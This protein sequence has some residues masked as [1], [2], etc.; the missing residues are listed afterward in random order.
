MKYHVLLQLTLSI[1]LVSTTTHG[2]PLF[3]EDSRIGKIVKGWIRR[4]SLSLDKVKR[5]SIKRSY[6][7]LAP[8]D[9]VP[10]LPYY[11]CEVPGQPYLSALFENPIS[12]NVVGAPGRPG[13]QANEFCA[14]HGKKLL[15]LSPSNFVNAT[16]DLANI[17]QNF[18]KAYINSY[19]GDQTDLSNKTCLVLNLI[20][21]G[22]GAAVTVNDCSECLP[23]ICG[24]IDITPVEIPDYSCSRGDSPANVVSEHETTFKLFTPGSLGSSA[25]ETCKINGLVLADVTNDKF[26]N[27]SKEIFYSVGR[28]GKAFIKSING[29]QYDGKC[30]SLALHNHVAGGTVLVE[31]CDKCLPV[32]CST[33]SQVVTVKTV[34]ITVTLGSNETAQVTAT[35][36]P[37]ILISP[38]STEPTASG[39]NTVWVTIFV[40]PTSSTLEQSTTEIP[41]IESETQTTEPESSA[42]GSDLI[43]TSEPETSSAVTEVVTTDSATV[44][45][46]IETLIFTL[47]DAQSVYVTTIIETIYETITIED[48]TTSIINTSVV[49]QVIETGTEVKTTN[50]STEEIVTS[51]PESSEQAS[52]SATGEEL[53]TE[54]EPTEELTLINTSKISASIPLEFGTETSTLEIP[55]DEV[56]LEPLPTETITGTVSPETT[57][58]ESQSIYTTIVTITITAESTDSI[59]LTLSTEIVTV[60]VTA[61]ANESELPTLEASTNEELSS[62]TSE[63]PSPE[64]IT[65][66]STS[67]LASSESTEESFLTESETFTVEN[68]L[69]TSIVTVTVTLQA[70]TSESTTELTSSDSTI[71][72]ITANETL[73]TEIVTVTV[74]PESISS[75]STESG[76]ESTTDGS[77]STTLSTEIVTITV[78]PESSSSETIESGSESPIL[79]TEIVTVT[80]TVPPSTE[81]ITESKSLEPVSSSETATESTI[82]EISTTFDTSVETVVLTLTLDNNSEATVTLDT[83][84]TAPETTESTSETASPSEYFP[85]D[86]EFETVFETQIVD[87]TSEESS[88]S[89][90]T[91][92][93]TTTTIIETLTVTVSPPSSSTSESTFTLN[94]TLSTSIETTTITDT[95]VTNSV[96]TTTEISPTTQEPTTVSTTTLES[97]TNSTS[98]QESTTT[99]TT[100]QETTT[101]TVASPTPS[102]NFYTCNNNTQAELQQCSENSFFNVYTPGRRASEAGALCKSYGEKLAWPNTGKFSAAVRTAKKCAG[103]GSRVW[104]QG[105]DNPTTQCTALVISPT[106]SFL[107]FVPND[108]AD[109]LPVLCTVLNN[110]AT[111]IRT[112]TNT[113]SITP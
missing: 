85:T 54:A 98:T 71:S 100:T 48:A 8:R 32:L 38:D 80:I 77:S 49:S 88:S 101:T 3:K 34:Y 59:E 14:G 56:T 78:T 113:V 75:E 51:E 45:P 57:T 76:T 4:E 89:S 92:E 112:T 13:S 50:T 65:E 20:S 102:P 110:T 83:P 21:K 107:G 109:C 25:E 93:I 30:L 108:C 62:E 41:S 70:T 35:P 1:L 55:T 7:E 33:P 99:T 2:R 16:I 31:E 46:V 86:G 91:T 15:D 53:S 60:T 73:S 64:P 81:S 61:E 68:I 26:Y 52:E 22:P 12:G 66:E 87:V 58:T 111:T 72:D 43:T 5:S 95:S 17:G 96:I 37:Q 29:N 47:T 6:V 18:D 63:T 84:T 27:A 67:E 19:L 24:P 69:S 23:V 10:P 9:L 106:G 105:F 28:W 39:D 44:S 42:I 97:T 40:T 36:P 90:T 74:T 94:D 104:V 103:N 82:I 11:E 79:S